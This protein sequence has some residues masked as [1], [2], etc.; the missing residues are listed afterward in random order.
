[1]VTQQ[2]VPFNMNYIALQ[3]DDTAAFLLW[4]GLHYIVVWWHSSLFSKTD[5]ITLHGNDAAAYAL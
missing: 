4:Y 2:P 3:F 5:W 1:M